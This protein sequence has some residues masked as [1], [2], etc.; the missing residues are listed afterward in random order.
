[1][2]LITGP[3]GGE[4]NFESFSKSFL[5]LV[6]YILQDS[7]LQAKLELPCHDAMPPCTSEVAAYVTD[8]RLGHM[9]QQHSDETKYQRN[10]RAC[11]GLKCFK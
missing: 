1:M 3:R 9:M 4:N 8:G 6:L 5:F 2:S 11:D 10:Q 7:S